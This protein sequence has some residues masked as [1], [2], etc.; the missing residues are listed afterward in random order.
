MC[1]WIWSFFIFK[2]TKQTRQSWNIFLIFVILWKPHHLHLRQQYLSYSNAYLAASLCSVNLLSILH[3]S[4]WNKQCSHQTC[5][6][7]CFVVFCVVV[8]LLLVLYCTE[9]ILERATLYLKGNNWLLHIWYWY[10]ESHVENQKLL[11]GRI[12]ILY[13]WMLLVWEEDYE[14][15]IYKGGGHKWILSLWILWRNMGEFVH[16]EHEY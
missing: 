11:R 2:D 9:Q 6:S 15:N 4:K 8:L 10:T 1:L 12:D 16:W 13:H 7:C 3:Y 14:S 5:C